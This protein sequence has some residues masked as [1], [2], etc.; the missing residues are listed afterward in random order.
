MSM[1]ASKDL[2]TGFFELRASS[3]YLGIL[4]VKFVSRVDVECCDLKSC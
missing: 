2:E 3:M 1:A 4:W